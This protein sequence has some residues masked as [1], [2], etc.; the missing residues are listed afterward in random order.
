LGGC[1][2]AAFAQRRPIPSSKGL[3]VG[4]PRYGLYVRQEDVDAHLARL[5]K[6][7]ITHGR[8]TQTDRDGESGVVVAFEDEDQNQLEFWAPD[9]MPAGAMDGCSD[10]GVGRV[11]HGIFESRDLARTAAL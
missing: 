7:G 1:H 3:G 9:R 2:I 10:L 5:E 8:P 4:G 11:R 6:L